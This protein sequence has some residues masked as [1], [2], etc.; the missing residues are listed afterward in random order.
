V[1]GTLVPDSEG[2]SRLAAGDAR[3]RAYLAT[4]LARR[5]RVVVSAITL[6][7]LLGGDPRDAP[8]YRVLSRVAVVPVS[9][10]TGRHAGV[11]L[12]KA[13]LSGHRSALPSSTCEAGE[14]RVGRPPSAPGVPARRA[15]RHAGLW[16][17]PR[18]VRLDRLRVGG[19]QARLPVLRDRSQYLAP[20]NPLPPGSNASGCLTA[21][22]R[23]LTG[24][25]IAYLLRTRKRC[26]ATASVPCTA[27]LTAAA[28]YGSMICRGF[29]RRYPPGQ[30]SLGTARGGRGARL[31]K[32]A[33]RG[34]LRGARLS[35]GNQPYEARQPAL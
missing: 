21:S 34:L 2:L 11:L 25:C 27:L 22:T 18:P 35:P 33:S 30:A 31:G 12:G 5:A 26:P 3:A 1:G 15:G 23:A 24:R 20:V 32:H 17:A 6:T 13:G 10:E 7:E 9:P 8:L 28:D 16:C 14:H 4:A 29:G 19:V